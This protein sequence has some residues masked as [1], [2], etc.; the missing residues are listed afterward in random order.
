MICLIK[1]TLYVNL[2]YNIIFIIVGGKR[3]CR[4]AIGADSSKIIVHPNFKF[5]LVCDSKDAYMMVIISHY[6]NFIL[7]SSFI[8]QI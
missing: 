3:F 7:G 4:V 6:F 2:F 8:K 1:I 5:I